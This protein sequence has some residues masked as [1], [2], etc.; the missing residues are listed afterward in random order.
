[1]YLEGDASRF[2][3]E[4]VSFRELGFDQAPWTVMTIYDD[5]SESFMGGVRL[6]INMDHP[7]GRLAL[8]PKTA[9]K[10]EKLLRADVLRLLVAKAA[11]Q[12]EE[13]NEYAFEEGTVGQVLDAMC[14]GILKS[15]LRTAASIYREDPAR[16]ERLL[17]ERLN[18]LAGVLE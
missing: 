3:T 6:L 8:D 11:G 12:V 1:L 4:P 17:H 13:A 18:P 9:P 10:V 15:G 2:P 14:Q 5:L 7:I 16:F